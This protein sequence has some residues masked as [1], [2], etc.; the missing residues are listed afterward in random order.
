[1]E[2]EM[3][4]KA[5]KESA[6]IDTM[7]YLNREYPAYPCVRCKR[8]K[9]RGGCTSTDCVD[10]AGWFGKTWEEFKKGAIKNDIH[11]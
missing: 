5:K 8:V 11:P 2:V 6:H 4:K 10:W 7:I 9:D 3:A 1:M